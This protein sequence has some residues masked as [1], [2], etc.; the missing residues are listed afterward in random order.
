MATFLGSGP[1]VAMIVEGPEGTIQKIRDL[2]GATSPEYADK[3][4]IRGDY[5]IDSYAKANGEGRALENLVHASESV[6]EAAR[7]IKLWFPELA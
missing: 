3:G 7:E 4:T 1:V 2:V 6:P 5:G